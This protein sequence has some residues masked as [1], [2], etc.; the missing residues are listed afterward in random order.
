MD[1]KSGDIED[2]NVLKKRRKETVQRRFII[3]V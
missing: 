3:K 1:A 2:L